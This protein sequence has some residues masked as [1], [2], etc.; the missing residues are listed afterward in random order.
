M[1]LVTGCY[2]LT[3]FGFTM[4]TRTKVF[5]G[6]FMKEFKEIHSKAFPEDKRPPDAGYPDCG[7]GW[8]SKQLPY[9]DW[10]RMN[11]AQRCQLNYL[12]Q[13]PVLLA[14]ILIMGIEFPL[15]T[16]ILSIL[17]CLAR[18]MYSVGYMKAPKGR[19]VG[20]ISQDLILL[21]MICGAYKVGVQFALQ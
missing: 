4:G 7:S 10:F 8:Y 14:A 20:A 13:L 9:G 11:C 15:Y 2:V 12:E 1:G 5:K 19:V 17:Y 16:L 3:S 21:I 18:L 6:P